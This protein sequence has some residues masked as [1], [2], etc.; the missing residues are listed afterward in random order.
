MK[1]APFLELKDLVMDIPNRT[2]GSPLNFQVHP[3]ECWGVLGPNGVG[4]TTLLLT[5]AGLLN[6][7]QG[8]PLLKGQAIQ[9]WSARARARQLAVL[10][11]QQQ[12][13]FPASVLETALTSRHPHLKV[14]QRET[15]EDWALARRS[16]L[17]LELQALEQRCVTTL[18]GGERQR[19]ALA[20]LLTQQAPLWLLDEPTNHLDLHHQVS[21]LELVK[22]HVEAGGAS[23]LAM[24]DVN[25]ASRFCTHLLLLYPDGSAC[26]GQKDQMLVLSALEKLYQQPLTRLEHQ[27]HLLF[28]PRI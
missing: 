4:K 8:K 23:L 9:Q 24:H 27:G 14:W 10:F 6:P 28:F 7:R 16:L 26:W 19:L 17:R 1:S 22:Q 3:G 2:S 11:Q 21:A 18:S 13:A 20:C 25:L 5:L 15:P 12:D